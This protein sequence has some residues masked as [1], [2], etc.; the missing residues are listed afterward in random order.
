MSSW[1]ASATVSELWLKYSLTRFLF[2]ALSSCRMSPWRPSL[3]SSLTAMRSM[4]RLSCGSRETPKHPMKPGRSV[5]LLEVLVSSRPRESVPPTAALTAVSPPSSATFF[6]LFPPVPFCLPGVDGNGKTPSKSELHHLYLTEK[7]VWRWKQFLSRRG[8][9]TSPLDLK[10]GHN[11]WLRQVSDPP[12]GPAQLS[13]PR[14]WASSYISLGFYSFSLLSCKGICSQHYFYNYPKSQF[15]FQIGSRLTVLV[16]ATTGQSRIS[17]PFSSSA[18]CSLLP[19]WPLCRLSHSVHSPLFSS[20]LSYLL[21][22]SPL[23]F[24][25]NVLKD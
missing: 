25:A 8:K 6:S 11:N 12:L 3:Q 16:A 19:P 17:L 18:S 4:P 13:G 24:L 21:L 14:Y 20:S 1:G 23:F 2:V 9:R 15:A 7:Y 22:T 5:F 10:L